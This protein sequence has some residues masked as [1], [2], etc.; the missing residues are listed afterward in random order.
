MLTLIRSD[1]RRA[2][3]SLPAWVGVFAFV[4]IG[5]M[6]LAWDILN[7][8]LWRSTMQ[9]EFATTALEAR[10][11]A[12]VSNGLQYLFPVLAML[13]LG[14]AFCDDLS[15]G[16]YKHILYRLSYRQYLV[17]RAISVIL[18]GGLVILAGTLLYSIVLALVFPPFHP[19]IQQSFAEQILQ[20]PA[21]DGGRVP[22]SLYTWVPLNYLGGVLIG[23]IDSLLWV[24]QGM[25]WAALGLLSSALLPNRYVAMASPFILGYVYN[26]SLGMIGVH[27]A[28]TTELFSPRYIAAFSPVFVVGFAFLP[29]VLFGLLFLL[30]AQRRLANE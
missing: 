1:L 22:A 13:P 3:T 2:I 28:Q 21:L 12:C 29:I 10:K 6:P 4:L 9:L 26:F 17:G 8:D 16:Y 23:C 25:G 20:A 27:I 18:S 15:T 11:A 19:G 7:M 24:L 5:L 14:T 30:V